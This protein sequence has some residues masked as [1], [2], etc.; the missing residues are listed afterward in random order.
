MESIS[1][2]GQLCPWLESSIGYFGH[3]WR[4]LDIVSVVRSGRC[5]CNHKG[6]RTN[7]FILD[8]SRQLQDPVQVVWAQGKKSRIALAHR[9]DRI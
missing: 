6:K 8:G 5:C 2:A 7:G 3:L 1:E 9:Q 4:Y